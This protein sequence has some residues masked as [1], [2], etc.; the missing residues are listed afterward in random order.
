MKIKLI[1][2]ALLMTFASIVSYAQ[3]EP[4]TL[5]GD[6]LGKKIG[7]MVAPGVGYTRMDKA[8]VLLFN[9]RGGLVFADKFTIGGY[10]SASV[11]EFVPAS[12]TTP[13][14][15]MDYRVGGLLMEYTVLS[16][17]I[18]HLTFP[19]Q[20]GGGE[21][22][23][24]SEQGS[25]NFG[26]A[27]FFKIEPGALLEINLHKYIR[28]NTGISYRHI[29]SVSYRNLTAQDL[30]GIQVQASIKIGMFRN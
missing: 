9:I 25:A 17:K 12:E 13:G 4:A 14:I 5:F 3:E 15:Y 24:D 8:D 7:V 28:L 22:E 23:M 10:Y 1:A 11:N 19:L 27:N 21:V 2:W 26:E 29:G 6:N 30:S 18:F 20:I 16:K